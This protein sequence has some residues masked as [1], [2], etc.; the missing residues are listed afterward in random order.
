MCRLKICLWITGIVCLFSGVG[1]VLPMSVYASW[2]SA[3]GI[4]GFPETP[5]MA[6]MIRA[7][8]A[9][10]AAIGVFYIML[11]LKPVQYPAMTLFS[12]LAAVFVGA[13]CAIT[14]ATTHMPLWYLGD[15]LPCLLLGVLIVVFRRQVAITSP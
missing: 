11:A 3:F 8:C 7:M 5:M 2:A 12:G 6:Y 10:F 9:T 4:D 1:L 13:T 15:A 14:G